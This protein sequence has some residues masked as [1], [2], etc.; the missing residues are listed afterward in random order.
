MTSTRVEDI[1]TPRFTPAQCAAAATA[2]GRSDP[3][4]REV[5]LGGFVAF[6]VNNDGILAADEG[7]DPI[8]P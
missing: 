3:N 2:T 8:L 7:F 4:Y 1:Y 6:D 5:G